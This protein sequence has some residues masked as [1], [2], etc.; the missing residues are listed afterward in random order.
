VTFAG[1]GFIPMGVALF[2]VSTAPMHLEFSPGV[3]I[4]MGSPTLFSFPV[5]GT[6]NLN[7]PLTLPADPILVGIDFYA[8]AVGTDLAANLIASNGIHLEVCP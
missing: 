4:L 3:V 7:L 5:D 8:Q 6:G 2:G 1:S